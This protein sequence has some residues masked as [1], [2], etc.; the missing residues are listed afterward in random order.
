MLAA[1]C[2]AV[3]FGG[4]MAAQAEQAPSAGMAELALYTSDDIQDRLT[5]S[6]GERGAALAVL[7]FPLAFVASVV[8]LYK[9]PRWREEQDFK[10]QL[11][12]GR[13]A[14]NARTDQDPE[15]AILRGRTNVLEEIALGVQ[16]AWP[17]PCI[18]GGTEAARTV[19]DCAFVRR[20]ASEM[21]G[22]AGRD[23]ELLERVR[24][25]RDFAMRYE[26]EAQSV[27]ASRN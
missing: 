19:R 4:V 6:L 24:R 9:E 26:R 5:P 14:P 17:G 20:E 12:Q 13:A 10:K 3:M 1:M 27:L 16:T 25:V 21:M 2:S 15:L 11:R 8:L 7:S 18:A 22:E 23:H